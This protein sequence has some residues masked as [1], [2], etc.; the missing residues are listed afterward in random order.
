M[1]TLHNSCQMCVEA[2]APFENSKSLTS[3]I[4]F[5]EKFQC[6]CLSFAIVTISIL[7]YYKGTQ[8]SG[9]PVTCLQLA[10]WAFL[11]KTQLTT[12]NS[13]S[14]ENILH[15]HLFCLI[16]WLFQTQ[17]SNCVLDMKTTWGG[18]TSYW[19]AI[20]PCTVTSPI[21]DPEARQHLV[22]IVSKTDNACYSAFGTAVARPKHSSWLRYE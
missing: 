17:R 10:T 22:I 3:W 6:H 15:D 21:C 2:E 16:D 12:Q 7:S 18:W 19:I 11:L 13:S 5:T 8:P 1:L 9:L 20:M 4:W 14:C